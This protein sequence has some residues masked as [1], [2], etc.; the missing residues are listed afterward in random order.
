MTKEINF[1]NQ[2]DKLLKKAPRY[3]TRKW[4]SGKMD[5]DR[6]TFWRKVNSDSFDKNEK[7]KIIGL[8]INGK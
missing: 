5:M 4:I 1:K 3:R 8:I 7:S 2:I 6:T